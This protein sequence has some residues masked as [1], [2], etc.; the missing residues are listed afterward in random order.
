MI[1]SLLKEL[2]I[3][4][5]LGELFSKRL[6]FAGKQYTDGEIEREVIYSGAFDLTNQSYAEV[7]D[8]MSGKWPTHWFCGVYRTKLI[9]DL[10]KNPFPQCQSHDRVFMCE[11]ALAPRIFSIPEVLHHKTMY[12]QT[13][14]ERY[15]AQN[16]GKVFRDPQSQ[17]K[18]VVAM[19]KRLVLSPNI[20]LER[21]LRLY[22][23]HLSL[24]VWRNRVFL[25]EW[26][27]RLFRA[28]L[29]I[30]AGVRRAIARA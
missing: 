16:V 11:L 26:F 29:H 1:T 7:F 10:M 30:R 22:P 20:P 13:L 9:Q 3:A 19:L 15:S 24:F 5:L 4:L 8:K 17:T 28:A 23:Y 25:R 2:L 12:R 18:Y 6:A 14:A 21:K 27:P